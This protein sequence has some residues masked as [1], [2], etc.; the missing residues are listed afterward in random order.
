VKNLKSVETYLYE[1]VEA[2]GKAGCYCRHQE[3]VAPVTP[4]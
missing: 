4:W 2:V 1:G 3:V